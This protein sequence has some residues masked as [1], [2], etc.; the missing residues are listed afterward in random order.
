MRTRYQIPL[1][2]FL[3]ADPLR[4][5][6]VSGRPIATAGFLKISKRMFGRLGDMVKSKSEGVGGR[7]GPY[8]N[9]LNL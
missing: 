3:V 2:T 9:V 5:P 4:N 6:R 1:I 7:V 8:L